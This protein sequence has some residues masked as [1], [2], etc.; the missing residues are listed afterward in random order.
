MPARDMREPAVRS[1]R[2]RFRAQLGF[3]AAPPAAPA[4]AAIEIAP[5]SAVSMASDSGSEPD[6]VAHAGVMKI[7]LP[8]S[9][10]IR[11]SSSIEPAVV[12]GALR[13]LVRR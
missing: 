2:K 3:P 4:F 6:G 8:R 9:G 1:W 11:I 12:T 13:V 10:R 7:E 5:A